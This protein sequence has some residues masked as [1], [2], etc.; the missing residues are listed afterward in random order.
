MSTSVLIQPSQFELRPLKVTSP[1][2]PAAGLYAVRFLYPESQNWQTRFPTFVLPAVAEAFKAGRVAEV[3]LVTLDQGSPAQ[4][5]LPGSPDYVVLSVVLTD[6]TGVGCVPDELYRCRRRLLLCA[7]LLATCA[8]I[9]WPV[10]PGPA[11]LLLGL[12]TQPLRSA[13]R[14][15]T[16]ALFSIGATHFRPQAKIADDVCKNSAQIR[17]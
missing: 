14:V 4:R 9:L 2:S 7:I 3:H 16:K 15:P 1:E 17:L 10:A 12:S 5:A 6:G 13:F 8:A 11:G